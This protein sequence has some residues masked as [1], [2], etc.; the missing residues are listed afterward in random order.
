[1]MT[2]DAEPELF[3]RSRFEGPAPAPAEMNKK[4][5]EKNSER[6]LFFYFVPTID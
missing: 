4:K 2:S 6:Y 5:M 3:G 1:M